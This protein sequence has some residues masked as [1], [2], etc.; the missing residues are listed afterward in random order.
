MLNNTIY[1][2]HSPFALADAPLWFDQPTEHNNTVT[3]ITADASVQCAME[4]CHQ[5]AARHRRVEAM[6]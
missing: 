6:Q 1:I 5:D 3:I 2:R 4:R